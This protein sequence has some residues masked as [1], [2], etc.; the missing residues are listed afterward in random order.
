METNDKHQVDCDTCNKRKTSYLLF[1]ARHVK[2]LTIS[3]FKDVGILD[4][5]SPARLNSHS[6]ATLVARMLKSLSSLETSGNC[7]VCVFYQYVRLWSSSHAQEELHLNLETCTSE[8]MSSIYTAVYDHHCLAR[9]F[10]EIVFKLY[11]YK[12]SQ[13]PRRC[14]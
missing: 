13:E 9:T 7:T 10:S 5:T 14:V 2:I 11:K 4:T 3:G 8:R 1:K 12:R 6:E